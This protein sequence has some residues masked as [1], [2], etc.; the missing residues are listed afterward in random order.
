MLFTAK[1]PTP[2][3]MKR[4]LL[5]DFRGYAAASDLADD[6]IVASSWAEEQFHPR[7]SR[8]DGPSCWKNTNRDLY[9]W[10]QVNLVERHVVTGLVVQGCGRDFLGW[11]QQFKVESKTNGNPFVE[12]VDRATGSEV[13][14]NKQTCRIETRRLNTSLRRRGGRVVYANCLSD[15]SHAILRL[16]SLQSSYLSIPNPL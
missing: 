4:G 10:I 15:I 1:C 6:Q 14:N 3:G 9:P 7:N 5:T 2:L 13:I 11:I 12:H 16:K 8:L